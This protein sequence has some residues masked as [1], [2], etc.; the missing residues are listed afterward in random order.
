MEKK[1]SI[2]S[3]ILIIVLIFLAIASVCGGLFAWAKY[4]STIQ[5]T[6]TGETAKWSF[7]VNGGTETFNFAITRTDSN[8]SV[9]SGVLAPGTY[10]EFDLEV[11]ASGTETSLTY[12]IQA[13]M[14]DKPTNL[15]FY[16]DEAKTN[17]IKVV[18]NKF[19]IEKYIDLNNVNTIQTQKIYWE[20]PFETGKYASDI[21][22]ND[23]IDTSEAG[24]TATISISVIGSQVA[25]EPQYL[26]D[27]VSVGDYVNYDANNN[28]VYTYRAESELTG[29]TEAEEVEYSS[30]DTTKWRVLSV[31][32]EAGTIELM[33]EEPIVDATLGTTRNVT[34]CGGV[35]YINAKKVLN[36][37][38]D[39]YGH[40]KGAMGGRS[41]NMNDIEQYSSF[42]PTTYNRPNSDTG[43]VGGKRTYTSGSQFIMEDGTI[44]EASASNPVTMVQTYYATDLQDYIE[45][46]TIFEMLLKKVEDI[47]VNKDGFWL[48]DNLVNLNNSNVSFFVANVNCTSVSESRSY[49]YINRFTENLCNSRGEESDYSLGG[50]GVIPVVSLQSNIKTTGQ[51]ENGVWQLDV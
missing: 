18:N 37:V 46:I 6:A 39:V 20:W 19:I 48:A 47:S 16:S 21:A 2:G 42:D 40:G 44:V 33:S 51:D 41:M 36:G 22:N 29:S 38:G 24:K 27:V 4:Q 26:V 7:K 23:K 50:C 32:K 14:E 11:D 28:G 15:K 13:L 5:G 45:N 12:T 9:K 10:G 30:A 34:L 31:N 25:K 35:G 43:T 8:T 1:K 3:N 49:P 17:E